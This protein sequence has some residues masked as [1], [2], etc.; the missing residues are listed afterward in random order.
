MP[1]VSLRGNSL[2]HHE[3]YYTCVRKHFC[4]YWEGYRKVS[5]IH[6]PEWPPIIILCCYDLMQT[7][8]SACRWQY[9][10]R[11]SGGVFQSNPAL[12]WTH[13]VWCFLSWC[14]HVHTHLTRRLGFISVRGN[15]I[16]RQCWLVQR[17]EFVWEHQTWSK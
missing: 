9:Y 5:L 8:C 6:I 12:L 4:V 13:S 16:S 14:L 2:S 15:A 11:E 1:N 3:Y 10:R 17:E 7:S